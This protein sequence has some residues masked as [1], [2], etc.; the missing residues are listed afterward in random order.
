MNTTISQRLQLV[1]FN[2]DGSQSTFTPKFYKDE[3][4]TDAVKLKEWMDKFSQLELFQHNEKET[5]LYTE[6][7]GA[8]LIETKV[9][10]IF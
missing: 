7:K 2:A 3:L 1:F 6:K 4:S 10:E 9:T 8:R 5:P